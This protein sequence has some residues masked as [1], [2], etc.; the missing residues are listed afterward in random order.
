MPLKFIPLARVAVVI[1]NYNGIGF[2]QKFLAG[3]CQ[4]SIPFADVYV[5]D[6][7][8]TDA[9]VQ[10]V[11]DNFPQVKLIVNAENGGFA[12]GYNDA[13]KLVEADYYVL[14]NSDVEVTE[15]W[16]QPVISLMQ[17]DSTIAA[18]Q[19][20]IKAYSDKNKFEYAGASGG[21]IDK[22]GFPFCRG[23]LFYVTEEDKG[24]YNDVHE[25][26]WASGACMFVRADLYHQSGGLDEDF[27]A[28]ME[29][30][31]LCWRLKNRGYKIMV[32]PLATVYHVGGGTLNS[33]SP[34]KTYLNFRNNLFL[35]I[36]NLPPRFLVWKIIFRMNLDDI[37]L[38]RFIMRGQ[39]KHALA[40][41]H[42]HGAMYKSL[43]KLLKKRKAL[44][45]GI[46]TYS[47]PQ[48]VNKS[49]VYAFFIQKK[50][51]FAEVIL[52]PSLSP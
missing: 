42:A 2:L 40:I 47:H 41:L 8:S 26:F 4:H 13:L 21:Y 31:D 38:I 20:K 14:L 16:L 17:T 25:V 23:R 51:T 7:A 46:K 29:E 11:K 49:V 10:Y 3:V 24:Q 43:S 12:K 30:I 22:Y 35:L 19:P 48:V 45:A 27:F 5:A 37:A 33:D 44:K 1:L 9:S 28:H 18:C 32:C 36:K 50:T 39:F 6:N 52:P 15:N 34:F